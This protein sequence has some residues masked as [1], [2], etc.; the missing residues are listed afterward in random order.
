MCIRAHVCDRVRILN[1]IVNADGE[2]PKMCSHLCVCARACV[3]CYVRVCF[4]CMCIPGMMLF[5][6]MAE[7][8]RGFDDNV[9]LLMC[10]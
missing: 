7:A 6:L 10:V 5:M 9:L 2:M 4:V 8:A 1:D 3:F